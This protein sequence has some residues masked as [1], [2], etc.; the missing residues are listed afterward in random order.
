MSYASQQDMVDR[1][2]E[3][4][5]IA[6]T[7]GLA[8]GVIGAANLSRALTDTAAE[9]DSYL[10]ARYTVPMSPIPDV[11][12]MWA[13]DIARFRLYRSDAPETVTDRYKTAI[14]ALENTAKG[15][16]KL[17]IDPPAPE[18]S[19]GISFSAGSSTFGGN[20]LDGL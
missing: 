5:L 2:G 1:Y 10:A 11:V 6:L 20:A 3:R 19:A 12:V 15:L 17:D 16:L 4:E 8:A 13:C 9:I 18:V 14:K 7:G